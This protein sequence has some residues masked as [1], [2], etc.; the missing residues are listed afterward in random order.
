[1]SSNQ[2]AGTMSH[3]L[4]PTSK[5]VHFDLP[6]ANA[7]EELHQKPT[8]PRRRKPRSQPPI[9]RRVFGLILTEESTRNIGLKVL[10]QAFLDQFTGDLDDFLTDVG[11]HFSNAHCQQHFPHMGLR[12]RDTVLVD[13]DESSMPCVVL[14]HMRNRTDGEIYVT[15]SQM[16][17]L[18]EYLGLGDQEPDWYTVV[19]TG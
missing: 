14:G 6:P 10:P 11:Q 7:A 18:R 13:T 17:E 9:P 5:S 12:W 2:S 8:R 16:R 4:S 3:T 15:L 19:C 1:M